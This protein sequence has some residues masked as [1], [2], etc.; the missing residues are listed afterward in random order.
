MA[1]L[2]VVTGQFA[3]AR[4]QGDRTA[5][6]DLTEKVDQI[7]IDRSNQ[8]AEDAKVIKQLSKQVPLIVAVNNQ[9]SGYS[10]ETIRMLSDELG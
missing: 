5:V 7:V 9:F 3:Y 2:D 4:L 6:D 1:E 10:P 8:L